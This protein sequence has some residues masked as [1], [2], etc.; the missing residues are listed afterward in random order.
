M[1]LRQNYSI[2][3]DISQLSGKKNIALMLSHEPGQKVAEFFSTRD[4]EH[5]SAVYLEEKGQYSDHILSLLNI[6]EARVFYGKS[7]L[8]DQGHLRWLATQDVSFVITVYW[9]WLLSVDYMSKVANSVNFHPA[10][11]PTNRGWYPHVHSI[12][13]GSPAG[14][15]LHQITAM[16]DQ[17]DIWVQKQVPLAI[18]QSS[19]EIYN[20]LQ[21]EI[22]NIFIDG[23]DDI[24]N[25]RI[26]PKP[27]ASQN[28]SYHSKKDVT[29]L[30]RIDLDEL[31]T[32]EL[33]NILR[34]RS[35]GNKGFAY[36]VDGD[37]K[38][39]LNLRIGSSVDF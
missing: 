38:Y 26:T 11:L 17:G 3:S 12:V 13:D 32:K 15:T 29:E 33:F 2:E 24:V 19:L 28:A 34:A 36:I 14:V 16:A 31:T 18:Y 5:I 7:V 23:W 4:R 37:K 21:Q 35:F 1:T 30:D 39:H 10:L 20:T 27:Q 9:P 22:V 8:S 25:Q 6:D